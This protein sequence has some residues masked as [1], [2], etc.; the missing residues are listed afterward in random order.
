MGDKLQK[1]KTKVTQVGDKETAKEKG[2]KT[3][4]LAEYERYDVETEKVLSGSILNI[5]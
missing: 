4:T 5:W 2:E 3:F 1:T